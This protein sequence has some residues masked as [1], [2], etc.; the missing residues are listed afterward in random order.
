MASEAVRMGYDLIPGIVSSL[1][2][3]RLEEVRKLA[4]SELKERY[5]RPSEL[6]VS[7]RPRRLSKVMGEEEVLSLLRAAPNRRARRA[8]L[9]EFVFGLRASEVSALRYDGIFLYVYAVKT[10]RLDVFPVPKS[11][12][13][14]VDGVEDLKLHPNTI[15]NWFRDARSRAGLD[16][17]WGESRNTQRGLYRYYNH[18]LRHSGIDFFRR[19]VGGDPWR[20]ASYSRHCLRSSFGALGYYEHSYPD[21]EF[22]KDLELAFDSFLSRFLDDDKPRF[23]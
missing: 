19:V 13:W 20:L 9:L 11:W 3:H 4:R 23:I 16:S 10:D 8:F 2:K 22:E 17:R 18:C 14:L 7:R 21:W 5:P 1:S 6:K 12:R 15:G